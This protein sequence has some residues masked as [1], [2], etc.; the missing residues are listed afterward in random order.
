MET[1]ITGNII[2]LRRKIK[3]YRYRKSCRKGKNI[4][5][6]NDALQLEENGSQRIPQV[7]SDVRLPSLASKALPTILSRVCPCGILALL[8]YVQKPGAALIL[9]NFDVVKAILLRV[10][11]NLSEI[12][13]HARSQVLIRIVGRRSLCIYWSIDPRWEVGSRVE[14]CSHLVRG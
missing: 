3:I 11:R 14:V 13:R 8:M 5:Q 2:T 10:E 7:R 12:R 4:Q 1:S 6:L 9:S